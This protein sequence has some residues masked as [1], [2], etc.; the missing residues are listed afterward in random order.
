[1]NTTFSVRMNDGVTLST[2][3]NAPD[4]GGPWPVLVART[5][6]GKTGLAEAFS[7]FTLAGYAV[8]VQDVRGTG[9]SKGS[10]SFLRDELADAADTGQWILEQP[11]CNG[12]RV[13][14]PSRLRLSVL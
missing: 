3:V 11:F 8:D 4:S 1:M 2:Q 6:Y 12:N 5:P 14:A 10:F 9:E 13:N 7:P